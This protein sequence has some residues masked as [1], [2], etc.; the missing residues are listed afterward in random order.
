[1][2]V[3]TKKLKPCPFCGGEAYARFQ[4][5]KGVFGYASVECRKCGAVPY[6]HSLYSLQ[7]EDKAIEGVVE[8]WNRRATKKKF[9]KLRE[10]TQTIWNTKRD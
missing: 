1:M 8:A 3:K 7:D 2:Q 9:K 6:V 5:T 4:R 10:Q